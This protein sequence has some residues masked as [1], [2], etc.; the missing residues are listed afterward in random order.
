MEEKKTKSSLLF[1]VFAT[2][3]MFFYI[4][5]ANLTFLGLPIITSSVQLSWGVMAL[6]ALIVTV[7]GSNSK[8]KMSLKSYSTYRRW[9]KHVRCFLFLFIYALLLLV[10]V[11]YGKGDNISEAVLKI[12]I[13]GISMFWIWS[14][15]FNS[16]D[17]F[18]KV[19]LYTGI[20]Q[21][22]VIFYCLINP[23]FVL[24]IDATLNYSPEALSNNMS[25]SEIRE[26]YAGGIGCITSSGL[27]KYTLTC[28]IPCTYFCVKN[29]SWFYLLLFLPL[30]FCATMLA[31][32]GLIFVII[33]VLFIVFKRFHGQSAI[34][35]SVISVIALFLIVFLFSSQKYSRFVE[36]RFF[37]YESLKEGGSQGFFNAYFYGDNAL[38]PPINADTFWGVGVTSGK[39]ANGYEVN[40]D[41]GPMRLY[42][43]IGIIGCLLFYFLVISNQVK[44]IRLIMNKNNRHLLWLL[45]V[46]L[47]ISEWKEVTFMAFWPLPFF[48]Y[49]CFLFQCED[50]KSQN[51]R[52]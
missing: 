26:L 25:I 31:R 13:Y 23:Y 51:V 17:E 11:G 21:A 30:A 33:L 15:M 2:I 28:L 34:Q 46:C 9:K 50:C 49:L 10:I 29:E 47:I 3:C 27:I 24:L 35:L 7:I 41:G 16:I 5:Q 44:T 20:L 43:A 39:S 19:L 12:F 4:Y 6:Y 22:I 36:E 18:M 40:V 8:Q 42:S 1:Y 37:R 48:F 14:K 32:T 38:Y 45:F 52:L